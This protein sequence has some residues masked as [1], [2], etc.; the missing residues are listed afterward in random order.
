MKFFVV[1]DSSERWQTVMSASGSDDARVLRRDRRVVP[2]RDLAEEDVGGRRAVEL[3]A[4]LHAVDV[5][6]DRD[7]AEHRRDVER[8]AVLGRRRELLVAE[9]RVGGAPVDGARREL[10]DATTRADALVVDG[11]AGLLLEAGRPLGVDRLR[12]RRPRA[13]ERAAELLA[14]AARR[15]GR[16]GAPCAAAVVIAPARRNADSQGAAEGEGCNEALCPHPFPPRGSLILRSRCDPRGRRAV[17]CHRPVT[18]S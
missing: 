11:R 8:L 3:Q 17:S 10:R 12:E 13:V 14:G 16:A 1:P 18:A 4:R 9:R 6:G 5:V 7:R 15:P 2:L